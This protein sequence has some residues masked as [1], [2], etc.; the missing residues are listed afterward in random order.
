MHTHTHTHTGG[1]GR[2][3]EKGGKGE[4]EREREEERSAGEMSE[5]RRGRERCFPAQSI[6]KLQGEQLPR[7]AGL[8]LWGRPL[9]S[10]VRAVV[11]CRM[12]R[13][14]GEWVLAGLCSG[15]NVSQG[16]TV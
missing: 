12:G 3:K 11:H 8:F 4:R 9:G 5:E 7:F 10:P 14:S 2:G 1:R 13:E 16:L 6:W 15:L